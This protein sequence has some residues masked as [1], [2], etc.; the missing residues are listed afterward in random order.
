MPNLT[1]VS[2]L[3]ITDARM[4]SSNLPE[5]E[6]PAWS[7]STT[8]AI[9]EM[10]YLASTHR[11][12]KSAIAGNIGKNPASTPNEWTDFGPTNR[13]APFDGS[14][15][16][17]AKSSDGLIEYRFKMSAVVSYL[18]LLNLTGA[19]TVSVKMVDPVAGVVYDKTVDMRRRPDSPSWWSWFFGPRTAKTQT[20]FD[21]LRPYRKAEIFVTI[22]GGDDLALGVMLFGIPRT[23]SYGV[24]AGARVSLQDFSRKERTVYGDF[25]IVPRAFAKRANFVML[26]DASEVDPLSN[27]LAKIRS[28]PSLW[29]GSDRYEATTIYG[30]SKSWEVVISFPEYSVFELELEGLT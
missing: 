5:S 22:T 2:P 29:V 25:V 19:I 10:V 30:F 12:Y 3:D 20:L 28:T 15:G 18:A 14:V 23:F 24:Q 1:I 11:V 27:F 17:Q 7:I 4:V 21:D 6:Y 8:Y 26:I 13:W 9:G 16:S